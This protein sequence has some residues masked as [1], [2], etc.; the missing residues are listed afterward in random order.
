MVNMKK[1][2]LCS[3]CFKD[4]GLKLDAYQIGISDNKICLNCNS[5]SGKKLSLDLIEELASRFFVQGT[6]FKSDYGA[7][8]LIQYNEYH[9]K[10]TQVDFGEPL[11][12]DVK[13]FE[14]A[15]QIGFF[16]YGPRLW[17]LGHIVPLKKLQSKSSRKEIIQRIITEFPIKYINQDDTFYRIRKNPEFPEN[18]GQ[19][20]SNPNPGDGRLDSKNFPI[21]Y[22]SQDL[23]V[24]IHECRVTVNDDLYIATLKPTSQL[25]LLDLT[26]TC[27]EKFKTEFESLDIAVAMLY[28]AGNH[29]YEISKSIAKAIFKNGFDGIIYPSFFSSLRTGSSGTVKN[30]FKEESEDHSHIIPNIALFGYPIKKKKIIVQNLNKLILDKV[31]YSVSFGPAKFE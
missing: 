5:S 28:S 6:V 29:S 15:L 17:T 12:E 16:H 9:Y 8:P 24:C 3:D 31:E 18:P 20:D 7:A 23:E 13:L 26:G 11:N 2:L 4:E 1:T 21:L 22:G 10:N 30:K 25:K 19:Y 27:N 14:K